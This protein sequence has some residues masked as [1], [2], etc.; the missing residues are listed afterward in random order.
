MKALQNNIN[1]LKSLGLLKQALDIGP[2]V[3]N[4]LVEEAAKRM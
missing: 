1:S 2:H 3:D 4:S